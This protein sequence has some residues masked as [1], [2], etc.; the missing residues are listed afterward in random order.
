MKR[1]TVKTS[2][3]LSLASIAVITGGLAF[4]AI[5]G[6]STIF[7]RGSEVAD[8][9]LPSINQVRLMD[10]GMVD[11]R[12]SYARHIMSVTPEA[13]TAAEKDIKT[14]VDFQR[15]LIR[16]QNEQFVRDAE[17]QKL[18]GEVTATL[19][20]Y[21]QHGEKV[22]ALSRENKND[23]AKAAFADELQK[24]GDASD[25]AIDTMVDHYVEQADAVHN[26]MKAEF[27][28][29]EVLIVS[30]SVLAML[31]TGAA[32]LFTVTGVANPIQR[33][34]RSMRGLADGDT[35]ASIPYAGRTDEIGQMA[36]AVEVFR[37]AAITNKRLEAEAEENRRQ[38]E[39]DRIASQQRAEAE[40]AERMRVATSGLAAGLK[41]LASGD[42]SFQLDEAFAADFEE[43]RRDF[44]QSVQQLSST[45]QVIQHSV[46]TM[47]NGA[48]EMANAAENLSKRTEQ[49]AASLEETA[50]ALDE[51]TANV[52][53]STRRTEDA[54]AVAT[55]ANQ[56]AAKSAGVVASAEEAMR[57][58]EGSSQ[59]ISNII[60]VIDEIAFQTNLLALNA[61][62]EAA[63]AGEAGK[64]FAVVAQEVRELAQRS[65]QAAREIKGLIQNSSDEVENGVK[66]VRDT[67][68][69]LQAISGFITEMNQHMDSIAT[70]AKEQ[71]IG[72]AEVNTAVNSMDQTT[73]QNAAMVEQST[74]ASSSLATETAKLRELIGQFRLAA[75]ERAI[76]TASRP[77]AS[78]APVTRPASRP[79]SAP[80][81]KATY[82]RGNAALAVDDWEEF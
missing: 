66:L 78:A 26:E 67:G 62:V 41:R 40:A 47:D 60:G 50:A 55:Q 3:I 37:Q 63:R 35:D 61:G 11:V 15:E 42:L 56:G 29:I 54:R 33:I 38:A 23:E 12:L 69:A 48:R 82:T 57:R 28:F 25:Q 71:S 31:I 44:N 74:A 21:V 22:L 80:A 68:V 77:L 10:K 7:D 20:A 17:E 34:T 43:L 65:A 16:K 75:G 53:S 79:Q 9:M 72:L 27:D 81:P 8:R 1:P 4:A 6:I 36:G 76:T 39:L 70:A 46:S 32:M 19:D 52:N 73:Q 18:I 51:I 30:V 24:Y 64:G 13:M 49:Q 59:Q 2:L 5:S 14:Y 45:L 58:I